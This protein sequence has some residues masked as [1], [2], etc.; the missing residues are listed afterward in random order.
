MRCPVPNASDGLLSL[1]EV[2]TEN[3][4]LNSGYL[5][6]VRDSMYMC[7]MF[8]RCVVMVDVPE[9]QTTVNFFVSMLQ[10]RHHVYEE[11]PDTFY[12]TIDDAFNNLK[13]KGLLRH[14]EVRSLDL[15]Y[16]RRC[17]DLVSIGFTNKVTAGIM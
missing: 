3:D 6:K 5:L 14:S 8:E 10:G 17:A 16:F 11:I 12:H 4:Q 13:S 9:Q 1:A 15:V 2:M 7:K